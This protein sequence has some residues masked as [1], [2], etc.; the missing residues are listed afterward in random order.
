MK[1]S[2]KNLAEKLNGKY[3][4]KGDKK[5][6]YLDRGYNT[7]KM[8]TTTYVEEIG[9]GNFVCK[10][11]IDCPSQPYQWRKSQQDG[12]IE[13][14]EESIQYLTMDHLFAIQDIHTKMYFD[15]LGD[16][17]GLSDLDDSDKFI[18][19]DKAN[20]EAESIIFSD[21]KIVQVENN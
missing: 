15:C 3:W 16:L 7:K 10:C 8:K 9:N 17:V 21:F 13:S 14:V 19:E 6:I 20:E 4:E 11:F 1:T 12:I 18:S 5:R 2:L